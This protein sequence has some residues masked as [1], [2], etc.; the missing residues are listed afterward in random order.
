MVLL[1]KLHL[2]SVLKISWSC[3]YSKQSFY[4]CL[5]NFVLSRWSVLPKKIAIVLCNRDILNYSNSC[6]HVHHLSLS[7]LNCF[8]E[9][10]FFRFPQA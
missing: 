4:K 1:T 2:L 8:V 9:L 6:W 7:L 3:I 10:D 5:I